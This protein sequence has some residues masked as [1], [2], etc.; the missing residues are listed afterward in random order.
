MGLTNIRVPL[1]F[2]TINIRVTYPHYTDAIE[3]NIKRND[4][5]YTKPI[6]LHLWLVDCRIYLYIRQGCK[7][8]N[9]LYK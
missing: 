9:E 5:T 2:L 8:I 1:A 6:Y 4:G 7:Y 3:I